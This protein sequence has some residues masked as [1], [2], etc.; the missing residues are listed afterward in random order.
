L[1]ELSLTEYT[2][3]SHW[4]YYINQKLNAK[5][6]FSAFCHAVSFCSF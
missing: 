4:F 3:N 2:D 1:Y 6:Y 5:Y